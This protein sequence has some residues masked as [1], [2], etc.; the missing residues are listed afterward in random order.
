MEHVTSQVTKFIESIHLLSQLQ[1]REAAGTIVAA[2][3]AV[4]AAGGYLLFHTKGT[5]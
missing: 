4:A 1:R 2:T 5:E 3:L